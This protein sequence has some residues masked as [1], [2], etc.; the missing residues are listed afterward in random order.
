MRMDARMAQ[1]QDAP[2]RRT[3]SLLRDVRVGRAL[4]RLN[5]FD[6]EQQLT[7]ADVAC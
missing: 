4:A 2:E 5:T 6:F 3:Y 1:A 7:A